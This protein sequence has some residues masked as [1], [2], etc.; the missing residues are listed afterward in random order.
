MKELLCKH[1]GNPLEHCD[2]VDVDGD[3]SEGYIIERQY[4]CCENCQKDYCIEIRGEIK[5][6]KIIYFEE[7]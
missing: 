7:S 4:W 5:E 6:S 1:C 2:T 3:I